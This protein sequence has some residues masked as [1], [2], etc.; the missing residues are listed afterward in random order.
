M[1]NDN[2]CANAEANNRYQKEPAAALEAEHLATYQLD[3][4]HEATM[5]DAEGRE[6]DRR[7]AKRNFDMTYLETLQ[8]DS[9]EG[10][11]GYY[12]SY[13]VYWQKCSICFGSSDYGMMPCGHMFCNGCAQEFK[14][15]LPWASCNKERKAQ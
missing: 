4:E 12:M 10:S 13:D 5:T 2:Q 1:A 11:E 15:C 3:R 7:A 9:L 6:R 8:K 14:K